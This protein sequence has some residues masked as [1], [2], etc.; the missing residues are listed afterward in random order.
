ME[1]LFS[2]RKLRVICASDRQ[3]RAA[4]GQIRARKIQQR[5]VQL[6]AAETLEDLRLLAPGR[7]HQLT[8]DLH[9]H[10]ALHL[11]GPYRLIFKPA[12]WVETSSGGLDWQAVQT[13]VV[14]EIVDYH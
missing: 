9:G 4:F 11:D 13:V 6:R 8:G 5:L 1:V 7:C 3:M 10:L 2:D 12:M 14:T